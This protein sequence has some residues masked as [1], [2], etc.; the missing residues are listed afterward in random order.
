MYEYVLIQHT[1]GAMYEIKRNIV[2]HNFVT[3]I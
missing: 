3:V 2:A 1:I